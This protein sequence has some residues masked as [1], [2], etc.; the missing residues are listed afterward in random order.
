MS[1]H[2]TAPAATPKPVPTPPSNHETVRNERNALGNPGMPLDARAICQT[3][4][5]PA[6]SVR[7]KDWVATVIQPDETDRWLENG[8]DFIDDEH[9]ATLLDAMDQRRHRG[10]E[11]DAALVREILAKSRSIKGL[12]LEETATLMEVRSPELLAEMDQAAKWIKHKVY[13]NRIVTFAPLYLSSSC[14][15][16]CTYCGFRQENRQMVR[17][18]VE[19]DEVRRETEALAR[20]F[21]HKRL[22]V[23]YGE[24]P[25]SDIDYMVKSID[26][27]YSVQVQTRKGVANIRRVN[28]NAAP[29]AME[30]LRRLQEVGVGT[31]Q[32]F[33]ETY[34]REV[35]SRVHPPRTLKGNFRWRLYA[36]HRAME[37]GLDDVGTGALFGLGDW[38]WEVLG[39]VA[40]N[41]SLER[42]FGGTGTHTISFPRLEPASNAVLG[43][44]NPQAVSDAD[45]LRIITILR[46]SVPHTGL[47]CTAREPAW[48]RN[49][50]LDRGITQMDASTRIGLGSYS[51]GREAAAGTGDQTID[52]QQFMLGDTRSLEELIGD[53]ADRGH[54]TS[55]CTAGY[56]V[57]RTG[58]R[59]MRLLRDCSEGS[60]CKLNAILTY[61]EW[62]DDFAGPAVQAK[63]EA[64]IQRE[65]GEARQ[66]LP[67]FMPKF[68]PMYEKTSHGCRDLY[69]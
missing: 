39:L 31:Y 61:R 57:G 68:E 3:D 66:R 35:Y 22:V 21:G 14:V 5:K 53:L 15:N 37:A 29:M 51:A 48:I 11:P 62:L 25:D 63:G 69:L 24:H 47:I 12:S 10:V 13:D 32:V 46:L 1:E 56:R 28:V 26:T 2:S 44:D 54:I 65:L 40:H 23:V 27:I 42:H 7:V 49:A 16:S 41:A 64:L 30:K 67:Q 45:F 20:D 17:R 6:G 19:L 60:F 33:Q 52:S 59:I 50:A 4:L 43:A 36:M 58:D 9:F 38:R 34:N 18:R 8:R 55:F